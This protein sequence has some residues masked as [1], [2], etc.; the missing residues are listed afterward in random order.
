MPG[1]VNPD[2]FIAAAVVPAVLISACGL[3]CLALY[4]RLSNIVARLRQLVRERMRG[5][6]LARG[7][8]VAP[9]GAPSD[10]HFPHWVRRMLDRSAQ[11]VLRRAQVVR[12]ALSFLIGAIACLVMASL[13]AG[14][15]T[16]W[17]GLAYVEMAFF[18]AG[19]LLMLAGLALALW[20]LRLALRPVE[21]ETRMVEA[22][23]DLRERHRDLN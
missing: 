15:T 10:E 4:N 7:L 13:A 5:D 16:L 1:A 23:L 2:L 6:E 12:N 19:E 3:L 22:M 9:P 20:E 17:S 8:F 18:V 11:G 21:I 14:L